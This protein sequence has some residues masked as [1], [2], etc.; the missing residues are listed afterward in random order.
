MSAI[1]ELKSSTK[2]CNALCSHCHKGLFIIN[3]GSHPTLRVPTLETALIFC[4]SDCKRGW[5]EQ[6]RCL[7]C[8]STSD[9]V[10]LTTS[11]CNGDGE[12]FFCD[13][14]H[15]VLYKAWTTK[16]HSTAVN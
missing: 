7:F 8:L 12:D 9:T 3:D 14:E 16:Q 4:N 10:M 15:M 11:C 6:A 5:Q 13:V 2:M 1:Q